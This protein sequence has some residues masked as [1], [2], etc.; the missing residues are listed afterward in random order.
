MEMCDIHCAWYVICI[1]VWYTHTHKHCVWQTLNLHTR[2]FHL[3]S[4][5]PPP[6]PPP[7]L[8]HHHTQL[9]HIPAMFNLAM[10]RL[11]ASD[12]KAGCAEAVTLLKYIAERGPWGALLQGGR[13]AHRAGNLDTALWKYMWAA[14]MGYEVA[15]AN[16]A[17]L[18]REAYGAAEGGPAAKLAVAMHR[19]AAGQGNVES[20]LELGDAYYCMWGGWWLNHC[21]HKDHCVLVSIH[22][23][24]IVCLCSYT[25]PP[26]CACVH[27]HLNH[28]THTCLNHTDGRGVE[29]DMSR[30]AE[31]YQKAAAAKNVQ[32]MFN[33]GY[34]HE[35]GAGLTQV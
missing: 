28:C 24:T 32:A 23:S 26:L 19:L 4:P 35:Y 8:P 3:F 29:Q 9:H 1:Y 14:E 18:L 12:S 7:T 31:W 27:T 17:W 25:P 20:I 16:A 11:G 15:Q 21:V 6:H 5:P 34:M 22:T 2:T 13:D 30:A 33:L 10:L